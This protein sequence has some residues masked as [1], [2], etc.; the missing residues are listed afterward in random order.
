MYVYTHIN[1]CIQEIVGLEVFSNILWRWNISQLGR[2]NL[3]IYF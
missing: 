3:W 1:T 2:E